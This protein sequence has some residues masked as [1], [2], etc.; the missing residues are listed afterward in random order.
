MTCEGYSLSYSQS[1]PDQLQSTAVSG[2]DSQSVPVVLG[3]PRTGRASLAAAAAV[4]GDAPRPSITVGV[5][6]R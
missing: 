2:S 6:S 1:S 5:D 4:C 3:H